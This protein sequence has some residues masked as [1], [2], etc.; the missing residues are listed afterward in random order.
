VR[1]LLLVLLAGCA[2]TQ[3]AAP[4]PLAPATGDGPRCAWTGTPSVGSERWALEMD[5][6]GLP[7]GWQLLDLPGVAWARLRGEATDEQPLI[8][9]WSA[10]DEAATVLER[11]AG[12]W[13]VL[14]PESG[15]LALGWRTAAPAA[16]AAA[17]QSSRGGTM[18]APYVARDH[19]FLRVDRALAVP[20][21]PGLA[22]AGV[23]LRLPAGWTAAAPWPG[24]DD[25]HPGELHPVDLHPVD[26]PDLL[27]NYVLVGDLD[28]A[29]GTLPSGST[30]SVAVVRGHGLTAADLRPSLAA[31]LQQ[32]DRWFQP[33]SGR[34]AFVV[35]PRW[36]G[37]DLEGTAGR[38]SA[39]GLI[40]DD[41]AATVEVLVHE[42]V[43]AWI[44]GHLSEAERREHPAA[45]FDE[46][47]TS[48]VTLR[49]LGAA[50]LVS[51]EEGLARMAAIDAVV[52]AA[53]AEAP[54]GLRSLRRLAGRTLAERTL[55]YAGGAQLAGA[56]DLSDP[57]FWPHLMA[58]LGTA[59]P[60]R[61]TA[62]FADAVLQAGFPAPWEAALDALGK[63][64]MEAVPPEFL[65][66][67]APTDAFDAWWGLAP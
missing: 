48:W 10:A 52:E 12:S 67:G 44:P 24:A 32:A 13:A 38:S 11:G 20:R 35:R 55:A 57:D 59:E 56:V 62:Q 1:L 60:G 8:G 7:P 42:Y 26:L 50:G 37:D 40:G 15:R 66:D 4:R 3:T 2:T 34:F 25:L 33:P 23:R 21:V 29:G 31:V 39:Q 54:V 45:W 5:C 41:P 28:A 14:V 64:L 58:L 18:V 19:G 30:W 46:G 16:A 63:P 53:H 36:L 27:D 65:H 43:H 49:L 22:V 6:A 51:P 47:F 61:G 9:E 17:L